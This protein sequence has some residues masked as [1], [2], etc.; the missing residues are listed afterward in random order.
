MYFC[1]RIFRL[2]NAFIVVLIFSFFLVP[3]CVNIVHTKC[4][5]L[6]NSVSLFWSSILFI[7]ILI[8]YNLYIKSFFVCVW[9]MVA[10][11]FVP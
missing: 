4:F 10:G 1:L 3:S 7:K 6:C 11:V 9:R 5:V 8:M 2:H